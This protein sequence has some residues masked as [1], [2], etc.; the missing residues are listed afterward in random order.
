MRQLTAKIA[1]A[2]ALVAGAAFMAL[3]ANADTITFIDTGSGSSSGTIN[4]VAFST[5]DF[6]INAVG[7][8]E[9]VT[10]PYPG[11]LAINNDSASIFIDGV[12]TFNFLTP[13]REFYNSAVPGVGFSRAP[14]AGGGDLYDGPISSA[15]SGWLMNTS[16]GPVTG[17][18]GL[19]Q[20]N[21]GDVLTGGGVLNFNDSGTDGVA[22]SFQAIVSSETPLPAALPLFATG[23]G[24]LGLL[25]WRRKR[26]AQAIA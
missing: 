4:G 3:P 24:A 1:F 19:F 12:G 18:A 15:F 23:L 10:S 8:T 13:T 2:T 17:T 21:F 26:K 5:S 14:S 11:V 9:N 7:L 22:G 20:W 16:I 25:G 6:T